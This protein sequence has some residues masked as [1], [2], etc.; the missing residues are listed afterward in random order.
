V[1]S[2]LPAAA[3]IVGLSGL[4]AC[5]T[6]APVASP[7]AATS[8]P[9]ATPGAPVTALRAPS[10]AAATP[11]ATR[12]PAA[13]RSPD[14]DVVPEATTTNT[15]P[16]P[17]RPS[18]PAPST[19]GPLTARSLPVPDGW[20][21]VARAGGSEEGYEGNGTW[22]HAR[23]PRYAALDVITLGCALVTRDDY[24][25]P[26]RALEGTYARKRG[27]S[28]VGLVLQFGNERDA[29]AYYQLYVR[30][31]RSCTRGDG[32]VRTRM[33]RSGLGLIDRR[34]YPDGDWTEVAA[35][36]GS[37]VTLI[38]LTD[39]GHRISKARSEA[40]LRQVRKVSARAP[41]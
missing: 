8:A 33:T 27:E 38:I 4:A 37:R 10:R 26:V 39:P 19:A 13:S 2:R 15:L 20:R 6:S 36:L 31:V 7:T 5:T 29:R 17:P 3:L 12:S 1:R 14:A 35:L 11:A 24:R 21:T 28:G 18:K 41:G 40:L 22:V 25:D 30:Q 16:P 9:S 34:T 23:D 32:P